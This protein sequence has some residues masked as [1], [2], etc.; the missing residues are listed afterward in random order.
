MDWN[1]TSDVQQFLSGGAANH[2]WRIQDIQ[3]GNEIVY[4]RTKEY[5]E[6]QPLLLIG[7]D[8]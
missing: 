2:G 1:V 3:G 5:F 4:F 8:T 6:N 7:Y